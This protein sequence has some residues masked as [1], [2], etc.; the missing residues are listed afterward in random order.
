M[1]P[2]S[3]VEFVTV[4]AEFCAFLEQSQGRERDAFIETIL[5]LLPVLYVKASLLPS[6]E[7]ADMF[8]PQTFVTE[9]DYNY[10]RSVV[11]DILG[12]DDTYEELVLDDEVETEESR[13]Q[14]ISE[15]LA[16]IY[17]PVRDFVEN[18]RGGVK[19]QIDESL[20]ALNDHFE[21]YWGQ[22]LVDAMR[23]LHTL[24][25]HQ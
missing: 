20:W 11:A 12:A 14:S 7:G 18:F 23:R 4:G 8:E 10:V 24:R 5:K 25:Y 17:Q 2:S 16:D 3:V 13:W 1:F 19:K 22:N 15:N 21:L 9:Q 6:V